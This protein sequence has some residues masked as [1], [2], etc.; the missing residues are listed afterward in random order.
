MNKLTASVVEKNEWYVTF[1]C[2]FGDDA[3]GKTC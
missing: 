3:D 2:H 1:F